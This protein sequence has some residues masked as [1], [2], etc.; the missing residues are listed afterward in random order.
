M[1]SIKIW[2]V[3]R[4]RLPLKGSLMNAKRAWV[5]SFKTWE[6]APDKPADGAQQLHVVYTDRQNVEAYLRMGRFPD[7]AVLVKDVFAART[8]VL[9]TGTSSY[10]GDLE[11]DP[12]LTALGSRLSI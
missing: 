9:T 11:C 8:E 3:A 10:A 5:A 2:A 1:I 6:T 4:L 12:D 7:G